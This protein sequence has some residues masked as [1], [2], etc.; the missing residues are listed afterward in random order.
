MTISTSEWN[1]IFSI[2]DNSKTQR[3]L[4]G[5]YGVSHAWISIKYKEYLNKKAKG[6]KL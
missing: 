2:L 6:E 1:R 5:E 4:A 3:Q